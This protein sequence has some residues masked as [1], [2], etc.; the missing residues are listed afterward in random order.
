MKGLMLLACL[1]VASAGN[2]EDC[3]QCAYNPADVIVD[4]IQVSRTVYDDI[5]VPRIV[6]SN[7]VVPRVVHDASPVCI[8][9]NV[10]SL[11][12]C[13]IIMWQRKRAVQIL[14]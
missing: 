5:Q 11:T 7:V 12:F 6:Y 3:Y 14:K 8:V 4:Q 13:K 1:A 9:K 2:R 10:S